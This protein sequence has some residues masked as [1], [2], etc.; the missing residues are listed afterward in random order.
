MEK[1]AIIPPLV[2]EQE[3]AQQTASRVMTN[4][5]LKEVRW[6]TAN[7][8]VDDKDKLQRFFDLLARAKFLKLSEMHTFSTSPRV[9]IFIFA[10]LLVF[11]CLEARMR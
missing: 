2:L 4:L 6:Q 8:N 9:L 3:N 10:P 11:V 7:F 1:C 5:V